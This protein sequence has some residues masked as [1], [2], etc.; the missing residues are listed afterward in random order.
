MSLRWRVALA[1]VAVVVPIALGF[2]FFSYRLRREALLETTYETVVARME[3]GGRDRCEARR[4]LDGDLAPRRGRGRRARRAMELVAS[5]D[6]SLRSLDPRAPRLSESIA[7][8][9]DAGETA[10]LDPDAPRASPRVALRMPW[11]E[12]PCAVLLV[13]APRAIVAAG[14]VRD[15]GFALAVLVLAMLAATLALGPPLR[16]LGQLS[17]A[18]QTAGPGGALAVPEAARGRDEIGVLAGALDRSAARDRAHV[19][20]LEA[21]DRALREYVDG[22]THDLALPLTV[23]QG[24]LSVLGEAAER[25]E[26]AD[27]AEVRGAAASANYLAQLAANLAA[28]ARLE[29][30]AEVERRSVDVSALIDRVLARLTPIARHRN[31]EL[32]AALPDA[33]L[34]VEGDELLLERAL[35]NLVH[36]AIRHRTA[37]TEPG[38]V[39]VIASASP[40]RITV[41]SDGSPIDDA[42]LA[43][44]RAGSVP[45]DVAR[46]R[47]RGLGLSIVRKVAA[48][49]DLELGFARGEGGSLEVVLSARE[50]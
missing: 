41:K 43:S 35:A 8:A 38:H 14:F 34:H 19:A 45:P 23:I 36:N 6:A 24:H 7:D 50:R 47:G 1:L 25:S 3:N 40:L 31:V 16:R 32:A 21:R 28:A 11:D 49:H 13:P 17:A 12:G 30:G 18:V 44:L 10:V 48:L 20:E 4:A 46:T 39:A 37:S 27:A 2:T 22:T 42:A 5:Y 9:F 33:P 26:P 15:L 29:G